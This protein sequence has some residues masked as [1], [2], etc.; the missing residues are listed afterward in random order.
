M[1]IGLALAGCVPIPPPSSSAAP[2]GVVPTP[3]T[4]PLAETAMDER[5]ADTNLQIALRYAPITTTLVGFTDWTVLKAIEG[6]EGLTSESSIEDRLEFYGNVVPYGEFLASN[7]GNIRR[8]A[9][10]WGWDSTDLLWEAQFT[11]DAPPVSI[12]RLRD[13]LDLAPFF[14]YLV[15]RE[16]TQSEYAGYT[17]YHHRLDMDAE[18]LHTS[19]IGILNVAYLADENILVLSSATHGLHAV[20]DAITQG[21]G[22]AARVDINALAAGLGDVASAFLSPAGCGERELMPGSP[23]SSLITDEQIQQFRESTGIT[24]NYSTYAAGYLVE[25][26]DEQEWP[27]GIV[28][29]HY[30]SYAEADADIL[31]RWML[32]EYGKSH[33]SDEP[34]ASIFEVVDS[35]I[36]AVDESLGEEGAANLYFLLYP[37]EVSPLHFMTMFL[38]KDLLFAAC[39]M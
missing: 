20:L 3:T 35:G 23:L 5:S 14:A 26:I 9:E 11:I 37:H 18:W 17:T 28:M 24:G 30:P 34:F 29:L 31:A 6:V 19:G 21:D 22:L 12:V 32:A 25:V 39:G 10:F 27:L 33:V 36:I 1:L 38:Q 4:A 13:D 2:T 7:F 15:E 8:H 16:Y